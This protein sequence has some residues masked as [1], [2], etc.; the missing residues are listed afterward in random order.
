MSTFATA[1]VIGMLLASGILAVCHRVGL[2]KDRGGWTVTLIAISAFYVVFAAESGDPKSLAVQIAISSIFAGIAL[3]GFKMSLYLV[4]I[5][6]GAHGLFDIVID[7]SGHSPAPEWWGGFCVG[8]DAVLALCLVFW[9]RTR[10]IFLKPEFTEFELD[11]ERSGRGSL[12]NLMSC[13]TLAL[14]LM[15]THLCKSNRRNHQN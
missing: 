4:A 12:T 5:G 7:A 10:S 8:V 1:L 15:D 3:V 6:L 13:V 9:I 2:H 11:L 14:P